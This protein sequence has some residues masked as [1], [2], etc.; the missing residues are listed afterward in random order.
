MVKNTT[1]GNKSK[2]IAR[3]GAVKGKESNIRVSQDEFEMYAIVEKYHGNKMCDVLCIDGVQRLCHIRGKF[4]GK[5]KRDN[6]VSKNTWL[7]VGVRDYE[8]VTKGKKPNCDLLEVYNDKDK[9]TL[10]TT[11]KEKWSLFIKLELNEEF[12]DE[13][14]GENV[15]KF[16]DQKTEEHLNLMT[17]NLEVTKETTDKA[18]EEEEDWIDVNDL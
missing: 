12:I 13:E 5:G 14:D 10:K 3:K 18:I 6:I 7:L 16:M 4:T 9:E 1:G 11:V 17:S 2:C 15:I 8:T